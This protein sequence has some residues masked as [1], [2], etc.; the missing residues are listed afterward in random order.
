MHKRILA[1]ALFAVGMML[2][3]SACSESGVTITTSTAPAYSSEPTPSSG[4]SS[5]APEKHPD[6]ISEIAESNMQLAMSP[7]K[8]SAEA[9]RLYVSADGDDE[10]I[11][12]TLE[13]IKELSD[14]ICNGLQDDHD[15]L[16]TLA[17]YTSE[18][19][20]YDYDA[21]ENGV[22]DETICLA[23]TLET[24]RSVCMG[25]A[26]L[27]SALCRAQDIT[28]YVVHGNAAMGTFADAQPDIRLHEWNV[29]IIDGEVIWI[30]TLWNT[31]N[32]YSGGEYF[33]GGTD[34][35]YYDIDNSTLATDHRADH[36]EDRDYFSLLSD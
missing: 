22:T 17:R 18:N 11:R 1:G 27:F 16:Y 19:Y 7:I 30:D 4:H 8:I 35:Y 15:K 34:D 24:R 36:V 31:T 5:S 33:K 26:N 25:Y 13:H 10:L 9:V 2:C 23:H 20:Y 3:L 12:S 14:S 6:I 29:A 21:K 32:S 28:C